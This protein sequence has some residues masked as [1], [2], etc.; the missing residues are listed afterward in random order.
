MFRTRL[1]AIGLLLVTSLSLLGEAA[2]Q[3]PPGQGTIQSPKDPEA[4]L[5]IR[6]QLGE[7]ALQAGDHEQ[8]TTHFRSALGLAP[9]SPPILRGLLAA[10]A[11]AGDAD[12]QQLWAT[13]WW[14]SV[15]DERGLYRPDKHDK[16]LL[17]A[18]YVEAQTLAAA[19]SAAV[20]E[21]M[22]YA[23]KLKTKGSPDSGQ[24][25]GQGDR[26]CQNPGRRLRPTTRLLP[27]RPA[28]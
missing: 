16:Q 12:A 21:L 7:K 15:C 2:G 11:Q 13:R 1:A 22:R 28:G 20:D 3:A 26:R 5:R 19:R 10:A 8:A 23:S 6:Q 17:P 4:Q 27:R 14:L 9:T 24:Q 18:N 25:R